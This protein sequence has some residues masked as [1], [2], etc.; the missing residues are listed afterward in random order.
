MTRQKKAVLAVAMLVSGVVGWLVMPREADAVQCN[1]VTR[2][3]FV[4]NCL[5]L[6]VD[7]ITMQTMQPQRFDCSGIAIQVPGQCGQVWKAKWNGCP[8]ITGVGGGPR[9]SFNCTQV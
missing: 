9:V 3:C 2:V 7:R 6:L 5:I 8:A 1:V 4:Q